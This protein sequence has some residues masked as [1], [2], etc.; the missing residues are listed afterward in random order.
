MIQFD[1][2]TTVIIRIYTIHIGIVNHLTAMSR[3]KVKRYK[4]KFKIRE[5]KSVNFTPEEHLQL[6]A[7]II[8][9]RILEEATKGTIPIAIPIKESARY[10]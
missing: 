8:I 7:N 2:L 5:R 3:Y 6:I 1:L 10:G 4:E 9:D